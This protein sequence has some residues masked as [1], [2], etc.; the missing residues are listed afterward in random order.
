MNMIRKLHDWDTEISYNS[1][2]PCLPSSV[3]YLLSLVFLLYVSN[4][5]NGWET[6]NVSSWNELKSL[7]SNEFWIKK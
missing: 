4:Q 6:L 1:Y 3:N 5:P 2:E 7:E